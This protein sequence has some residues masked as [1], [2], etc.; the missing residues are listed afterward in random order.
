MPVSK[1]KAQKSPCLRRGDFYWGRESK[2]SVDSYDYC[3]ISLKWCVKAEKA[4]A[5]D[6]KYDAADV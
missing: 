5:K 3:P 6:I 2:D 4:S 1:Y